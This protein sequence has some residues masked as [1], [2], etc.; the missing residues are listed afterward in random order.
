L[1]EIKVNIILTKRGIKNIFWHIGKDG[2]EKRRL[3][4]E[5]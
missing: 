3:E 1:Y 5:R 2:M 4:V